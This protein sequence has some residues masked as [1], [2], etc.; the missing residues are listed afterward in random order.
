MAATLV[1]LLRLARDVLYGPP[2][3]A[4]PFPDLDARETLLLSL[5]AAAIVWLGLFPG[6]VL[7]LAAEPLNA[8][9]ARVWPGL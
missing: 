5:L 6:P 1:Y 9:A 4:L 7:G 8:I 2:R 3:S